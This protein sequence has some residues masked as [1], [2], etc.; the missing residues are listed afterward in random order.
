MI[1]GTVPFSPGITNASGRHASSHLDKSTSEV[2]L[3]G[4]FGQGAKIGF[5][6]KHDIGRA[7]LQ[8]RLQDPAPIVRADLQQPETLVAILDY[9]VGPAKARQPA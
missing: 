9:M 6:F 4:R 2:L 1:R 8:R 3:G 5:T 7:P